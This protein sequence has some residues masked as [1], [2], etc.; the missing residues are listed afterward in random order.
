MSGDNKVKP[1]RTLLVPP[2]LAQIA[3]KKKPNVNHFWPERQWRQEERDGEQQSETEKIDE[4]ERGG[5]REL[6]T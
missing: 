3:A 2:T 5:E 6:R 1:D 4:T